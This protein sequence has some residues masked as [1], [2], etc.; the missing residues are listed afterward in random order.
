[1]R[2]HNY[3]SSILYTIRKVSE[4][5]IIHGGYLSSGGVSIYISK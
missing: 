1:M 2:T 4:Y 5:G 3:I